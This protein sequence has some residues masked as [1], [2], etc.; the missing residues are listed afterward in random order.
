MEYVLTISVEQS[1]SFNAMGSLFEGDRVILTNDNGQG[2]MAGQMVSP[3]DDDKMTEV[4]VEEVD[5]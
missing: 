5:E 2:Q 3:D 1:N 4:W